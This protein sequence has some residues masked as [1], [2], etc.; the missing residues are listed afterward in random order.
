MKL[1]SA[2][3]ER[4]VRPAHVHRHDRPDVQPHA[5]QA[6]GASPSR[7][8]PGTGTRTATRRSRWPRRTRASGPGPDVGAEQHVPALPPER[9]ELGRPPGRH[10]GRPSTR[11]KAIEALELRAGRHPE[12]P[13][14]G[15]RRRPDAAPAGPS[16]H[17]PVPG[18]STPATSPCGRG[19]AF[20]LTRY[21]TMLGPEMRLGRRPPAQGPG[22]ALHPGHQ[23]RLE[24]LEGL[25]GHGRR[26]GAAEVPAVGRVDGHRH[27]GRRAAER[28]QV[29]PAALAEPAIKEAN[30]KLADKNL[31]PFTDAIEK[32]YARPHRAVPQAGEANSEDY[33]R[34]LQQVGAGRRRGGGDV[35]EDR[36]GAGQP[37]QQELAI[38]VRGT[39]FLSG[40]R[41]AHRMRRSAACPGGLWR[42]AAP[43]P[44]S[45]A[46]GAT[47]PSPAAPSAPAPAQPAD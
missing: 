19:A 37:D 45:T 11:P 47:P 28:A 5:F 27:P 8:R 12:G 7:T 43:A 26:L 24:H 23:R 4:A 42:R 30:P 32:S 25:Q 46:L 21:M 17:R 16:G 15:E 22:G 6:E 39:V 10:Q 44:V 41:C 29:L 1:F 14:H 36:R 38:V 35:D 31:K 20:T 9:G 2:P 18:R 34:R 3:Q 13:L 40:A 33:V